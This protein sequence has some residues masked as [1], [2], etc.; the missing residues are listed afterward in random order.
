MKYNSES[1]QELNSKLK[2]TKTV[3]DFSNCIKTALQ[4]AGDTLW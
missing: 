4:F 3:K 2:V 1:E